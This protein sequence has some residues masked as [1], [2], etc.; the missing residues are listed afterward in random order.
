M[1]III[2]GICMAITF[3]VVGRGK[4]L[5]N[6]SKEH[7]YQKSYNL[8]DPPSMTTAVVYEESWMA[9]RF[10]A[11]VTGVWNFHCEQLGVISFHFSQ[12]VDSFQSIS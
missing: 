6:K 7:I 9:I 12:K 11:K 2:P 8:V 10:K 1:M 4:G 5:Y 3:F